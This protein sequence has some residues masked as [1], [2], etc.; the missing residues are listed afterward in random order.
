MRLPECATS[1]ALTGLISEQMFLVPTLGPCIW[2]LA[3]VTFRSADIRRKLVY[4]PT[5]NKV[6]PA[7]WCVT[8]ETGGVRVA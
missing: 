2:L 1:S 6:K 8:G 5:A 7:V 4:S 3:S